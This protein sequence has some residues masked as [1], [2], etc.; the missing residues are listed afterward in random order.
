[1]KRKRIVAAN[2]KMNG[3]RDLVAHLLRALHSF[4]VNADLLIFPPFIYI[5]QVQASLCDTQIAWGGQN[6]ATEIQGAY[7]GEV[8]GV[9]LK[10]FGC[11]YVLVGHSE[12]RSLYDESNEMV[13]TKFKI[14][15]AA[16]LIPLLCV[17][18]TL[19]ERQAEQTLEVIE[20]QLMAVLNLLGITAFANAI[21]A[22]EPVWAIGTGLTATP[23][24]A[25]AVHQEIRKHL[26]KK[27]DR[28]AAQLPILYGGSVKAENAAALFA[29]PD[30]DGA[31]VGGASLDAE[32]FKKICESF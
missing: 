5:P 17:G 32:N 15:Q 31:L 3:D 30:I 13:A 4:K 22:Y 7:T 26:A 24:Q 11:R 16:G 10:D 1:M 14:A 6:L 21:I 23:E 8:S 29:E 18:E 12:R 25:Q 19:A 2:W 20:A 9:M 28:I 27:D